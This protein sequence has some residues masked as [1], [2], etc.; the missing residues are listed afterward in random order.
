MIGINLDDVDERTIAL[1]GNA[2]GNLNPEAE[3]LASVKSTICREFRK[4]LN[5]Q[6]FRESYGKK[7]QY[8]QLN[9]VGH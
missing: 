8:Y 5:I 7:L 3:I 9:V 2:H 6:K 1:V 4:Q